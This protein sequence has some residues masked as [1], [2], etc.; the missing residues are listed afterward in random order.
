VAGHA[1][2]FESLD[3]LYT[4]SVDVPVDLSFFENVLR[5]RVVF[6]IA[7]MNT[8]VAA[9]ELSSRPPLVLL[10][11]HLEGERPVL[12]YRVSDLSATR[13]ELA[14]RGWKPERSLEIPHGPCSSFLTPGGYRVAL[15][16]LVRP[17]VATYFEG[18]RDF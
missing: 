11:D 12:V 18:R 9:V 6:A 8:R 3:F 5:A 2:P 1:A 7:D 15:Y 13:S 17:E 10:T 4:P 14:T 16:E